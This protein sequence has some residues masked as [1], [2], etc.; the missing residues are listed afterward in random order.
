MDHPSHHRCWSE[1][2]LVEYLF[3]LGMMKHPP[4]VSA[5][6]SSCA[7][8][9]QWEE[10]TCSGH[11]WILHICQCSAVC[12]LKGAAGGDGEGLLS[13]TNGMAYILPAK[14][15]SDTKFHISWG[16]VFSECSETVHKL[17]L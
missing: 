9:L 12:G 8:L 7:L 5:G 13:S 11:S 2:Y 14:V 15:L 16:K 17:I 4:D 3:Q 1:K 10:T 6:P